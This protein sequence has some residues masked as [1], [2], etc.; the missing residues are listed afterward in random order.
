[1]FSVDAP[2]PDDGTTEALPDVLR[3]V[4]SGDPA[5][6][7]DHPVLLARRLPHGTDVAATLVTA[8]WKVSVQTADQTV[9]INTLDDRLILRLRLDGTPC[10]MTAETGPG[11][12]VWGLGQCFSPPS[13]RVD[14]IGR[15]RRASLAGVRSE[16][17]PYGHGLQ[18]FQGGVEGYLQIPVLMVAGGPQPF[19]IVWDYVFRIEADF[20]ANP[21]R[22][23]LG[24]NVP[25]NFTFP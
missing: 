24:S 16:Y 11:I 13:A 17:Q 4:A 10:T 3:I 19:A 2:R 12:Q 8:T 6:P 21:W 9:V 25:G 20:R 1:M 23:E 5:C 15:Q 14:W 22:I 7:V 18:D